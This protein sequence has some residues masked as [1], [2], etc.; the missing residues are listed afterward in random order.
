MEAS[1]VQ[2]LFDKHFNRS[3]RA[4]Y[5]NHVLVY[6]SMPRFAAAAQCVVLTCGCNLC[7]E[8]GLTYRVLG[9]QLGLQELRSNSHTHARATFVHYCALSGEYWG[10]RK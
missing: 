5:N 1:L 2:G 6:V 9:V 3:V 8:D 4:G 7:G 10:R